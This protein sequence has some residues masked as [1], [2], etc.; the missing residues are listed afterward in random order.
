MTSFVNFRTPFRTAKSWR[1]KRRLLDRRLKRLSIV[2]GSNGRDIQF[3]AESW[4][5]YSISVPPFG[6]IA[7]NEYESPTN[8]T[9]R[10]LTPPLFSL[11]S[12]FSDTKRWPT[13]FTLRPRLKLSTS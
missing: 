13:G 8:G 7:Q 4:E 6:P 5:Q 12:V 10:A 1:F 9:T 3:G 2:H 11:T